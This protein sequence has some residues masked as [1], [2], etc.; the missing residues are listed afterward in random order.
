MRY[1]I[2]TET[3]PPEINGVAL[4]VQGLEQGLR[5]RGHQVD[6]VRPRQAHERAGAEHE[7]LVRSLPLPRYPGLRV[8]L[9]ATG[10]LVQTWTA[11]APDAVYVATEGPL[12]WSALRAARRLGIPVATG[13]HT[14][15]DEYMRD[16]G[17]PFLVGTALRWMR[18]FHNDADATL[19]PTRELA[20]FLRAQGFED[21]VRLPRAVDTALFDPSRR[22]EA[23]RRAWGIPEGG[24]A[25]IYVGRIAPE[26]NLDL[27][28]RAFRALQRQRPEARF[29]WVGD[30]PARA[31]LQREQPDFVFC[32]VQ[33][34]ADLAGHFASGDL[35]LFPSRSETFGNVTLEAMASGVPTVAFDYGAA[36]EH[37]RDG[38]HGAAIADGDEDGFIAAAVRIGS[39]DAMRAAM[40]SAGRAA[41]AGLRPEQVA[42]DFD[43]LLGALA[44]TAPRR[45]PRHGK[46]LAVQDEREV[47]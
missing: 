9:P 7:L 35:F 12:G 24:V 42:A 6:L 40:A 44:D 3:Y 25:A 41:I 46:T 38:E 13:F 39:D 10:R 18:R 33:R 47:V 17:A 20:E 34:G 8:G 31:R 15:F 43:A 4:T 2:V 29:V 36:H 37:L 19:V 32:G 21:V 30:G 14:R 28:V 45:P 26:K 5:A 22:S 11:Q 27:A 1:A 16:Y 23:L